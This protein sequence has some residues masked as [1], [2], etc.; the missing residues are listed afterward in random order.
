MN[1]A[2]KDLFHEELRR[3]EQ[4]ISSSDTLYRLLLRSKEN[5][6][7]YHVL[8]WQHVGLAG[9]LKFDRE[10]LEKAL[11]RTPESLVL[12][13]SE[14]D[15]FSNEYFRKKGHL[16]PDWPLYLEIQEELGIYNVTSVSAMQTDAEE[17]PSE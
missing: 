3:I 4:E 15:R 8:L 11:E 6:F 5:L 13:A 9:L 2:Q 14:W 7:I 10:F 17:K 12:A 16:V 1:S